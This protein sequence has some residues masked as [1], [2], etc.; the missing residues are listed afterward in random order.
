MNIDIN[1]LDRLKESEFL[2]LTLADSKPRK[3]ENLIFIDD[4]WNVLRK[5]TTKVLIKLIKGNSRSRIQEEGHY[6][7]NEN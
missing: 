4:K 1:F 2:I 6:I 7:V 5:L 3:V